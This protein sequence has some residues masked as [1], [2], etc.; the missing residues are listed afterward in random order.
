MKKIAPQKVRILTAEILVL[1]A[2][3]GF[4][5]AATDFMPMVICGL[6]LMVGS[7]I[8]QII[9]HRCPHCASYLGRNDGDYCPY[10]GKFMY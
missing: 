9:F 7:M 8:F 6:A 10:C 4:I 5:G 3:I 1:G 2:V